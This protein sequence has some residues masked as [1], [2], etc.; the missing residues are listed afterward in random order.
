MVSINESFTGARVC[1]KNGRPCMVSCVLAC[2]A[3]VTPSYG[4][5]ATVTPT[6]RRSI[7]HTVA[8]S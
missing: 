7:L 5:A 1:V 6:N 8:R 3:T 2:A 4:T